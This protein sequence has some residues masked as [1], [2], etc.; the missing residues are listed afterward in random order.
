MARVFACKESPEGRNKR[1]LASYLRRFRSHPD[2][3]G[4]IA[5]YLHDIWKGS[6]IR[7]YYF[8]KGK[9]GE[10]SLID[11]IPLT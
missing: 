11:K 10:V 6:R 1:L 7:G 3:E 2:P 4:A 5:M 8:D 9:I